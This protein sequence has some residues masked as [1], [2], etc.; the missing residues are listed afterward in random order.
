MDAGLG[1]TEEADYL[2]VPAVEASHG[3]RRKPG[4]KKILLRGMSQSRINEL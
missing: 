3:S 4:S 1:F 2:F